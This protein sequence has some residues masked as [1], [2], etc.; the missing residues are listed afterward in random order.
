MNL[1]LKPLQMQGSDFLLS[2]PFGRPHA[3]LGDDTGSGKTV[4]VIDAAKRANCQGGI[5]L[6]PSIVKEQWRREMVRW[7]LCADEDIQV[8]Y[9]EDYQLTDAPWLIINYELIRVPEI[10]KQAFE[11]AW[12]CLIEDE[13]HRL[14]SHTSKQTKAVYDAKY[15]I[16]NRCY[17]KWAL[18]AT[19]MPNRPAELY[20]V[21]RTHFPEVLGKYD[22]WDKYQQRYC[23]GLAAMGKGASNVPELTA[24][25]QSVMLRRSLPDIW[26]ECPDVVENEVY[27]DVPFEKHPEWIGAD[28][29][30]ESMMRRIVAEAKVPY[31]AQY[32]EEKLAGG[33][34]KLVVITYHRQV[35]E[36]LEK[37]LSKYN[38]LKIY[39][40]ISR[41]LRDQAVEEFRRNL[42][43]RVFLLQI[44][45]G[46][47]GLD[48]L[49][50]A[51]RYYIHAEPEWCP[52]RETQAGGR[53]LRYGQDKTVICDKLRAARSFEDVI[54]SSNKKKRKV[55]DVVMKPNGG[56]SHM[57]NAIQMDAQTRVAMKVERLLDLLTPLI[58]KAV[59][60]TLQAIAETA[61]P[62]LQVVQPTPVA[63]VVPTAAPVMTPVVPTPAPVP[64][65]APVAAP[66]PIAAAPA[67]PAPA[68]PVASGALASMGFASRQQFDEWLI[69]EIKKFGAPATALAELE[70]LCRAINQTAS[71]PSMLTEDQ[72]PQFVA[73]LQAR[74]GQAA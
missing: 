56:T 49:Q 67:Q 42:N 59:T 40:G 30:N 37:L 34:D 43:R 28:F 17:W 54:V 50:Y 3:L 1:S 18:S 19:L 45:S 24:A 20:A 13:V 44:M 74:L 10:R 25:L 33:V 46:G 65:P 41:K 22:T 69:N 16:A 32:V 73:S 36:G 71:R 48:G 64:A 66:A 68:A 12:H 47:E 23:G 72:L 57:S 63:P 15:G 4:M 62:N 61:A 2:M 21:L 38:P 5:I 31:V 39:G 52:G 55:I 70:K 60:L 8:A 14:K 35:T 29:M 27:L 9:G 53:V 58:E 7:G 26:P 11:R 51:T 6:C